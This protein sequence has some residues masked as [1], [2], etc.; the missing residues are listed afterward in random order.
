LACQL[1]QGFII[2]ASRGQ[3][4]AATGTWNGDGWNTGE[5]ERSGVAQETNAGLAVIG[6]HT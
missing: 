6:A 1:Q 3:L 2:V 5:A 4:H